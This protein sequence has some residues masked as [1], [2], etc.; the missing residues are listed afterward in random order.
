MKNLYLFLALSPL[1][2]LAQ[3]YQP[4]DGSVSKRFFE[5]GNSE[6]DEFYF[7]A[8]SELSEDDTIRWQQY[9]TTQ[10][11]EFSESFPECF[12]WGGSSMMLDTTWLGNE[13]QYH[14]N[15]KELLLK[16]E[17]DEA[18]T[19]N[20]GIALNDSALFYEDDNFSWYIKFVSEEEQDVFGQL[21]NIRIFQ[22][23]GFDSVGEVLDNVLNG[24]EIRI[25]EILGLLS[26]IDCYHFPSE[27]TAVQIKGQNN[28]ILGEYQLT[29]SDIYSWQPGDVV[30]YRGSKSYIEGLFTNST[31]TTLTITSREETADSVWIY[32]DSNIQQVISFPEDNSPVTMPLSNP[33]A[34]KKDEGIR[35]APHN[36]ASYSAL[37]FS[38]T[39]QE[40]EVCSSD[41]HLI[42]QQYF[43]TYCDS[44]MCY[45]SID[46]NNTTPVQKR[47][48]VGRGQIYQ[49]QDFYGPP[50]DDPNIYV[51][52][53]YS[54]I[55]GVECGNLFVDVEEYQKEE[56]KIFPNPS[57]GLLN[58]FTSVKAKAIW[59]V[60]QRGSEVYRIKSINAL[61]TDLNLEKL[62][63][64]SY[65]LNIEYPDGTLVRKKVLLN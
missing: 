57:S 21:E 52:Q 64:G 32:F 65:I 25:A 37:T 44:C 60:D 46:G 38:F 4:L 1:F 2:C 19:F 36:A 30:Q 3:N 31:Y 13:I 43:L 39:E 28:P 11:I 22:L 9:Y 24:F 61:S 34:F 40:G 5:Y 53:T 23:I 62:N 51:T 55:G 56:V 6:N 47:Y 17:H 63:A 18:L 12:F 45:G 54:N 35:N 50:Q 48:A 59:L 41:G 33:I 26:F 10:M 42:Y 20:F 8:T 58:V 49:K 27:L 14:P 29:Y 15:T 7:H 16:N